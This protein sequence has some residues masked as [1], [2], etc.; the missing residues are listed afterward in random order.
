[1]PHATLNH[2]STRFIVPRRDIIVGGIL[3]P[4]GVVVF[5][6]I[7]PRPVCFGVAV[8]GASQSYPPMEIG[9]G[10]GTSTINTFYVEKLLSHKFRDLLFKFKNSMKLF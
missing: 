2:D 9:L 1:M 6:T 8:P 5:C 3:V 7:K 10:A 4:V